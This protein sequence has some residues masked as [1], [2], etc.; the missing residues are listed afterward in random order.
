MTTQEA[1]TL[2]KQIEELKAK[3]SQNEGRLIQLQKESPNITPEEL[4]KINKEVEELKTKLYTDLNDWK[5][6]YGEYIRLE[7]ESK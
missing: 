6:K 5:K 1:N 4:E 2:K 3:I 7:R